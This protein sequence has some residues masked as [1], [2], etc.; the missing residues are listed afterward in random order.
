MT[1]GNRER[2]R[3]QSSTGR[4]PRRP[5]DST[6]SIRGTAG[7]TPTGPGSCASQTVFSAKTVRAKKFCNHKLV[8]QPDQVDSISFEKVPSSHQNSFSDSGAYYEITKER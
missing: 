6:S 4:G 1:D 2:S 7:A 8:S 5:R 3:T